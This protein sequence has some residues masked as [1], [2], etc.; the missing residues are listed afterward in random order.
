MAKARIIE[1]TAAALGHAREVDGQTLAE[2]MP[3]L[4]VAAR[5]TAATVLHG[6][7]GRRRA[8]P[9]ENFWQYRRFTSGEPARRIDW[10]RSARDQY[11]YVREREWEVSHT[12][13]LWVDRSRSMWFGS[14]LA[15]DA[16]IERAV[17]LSLGLAEILVDGG[18][19][20]GLLGL[21]RPL[22]N[23]RV[24]PIFADAMRIK[25]E[26]EGFA[27]SA[28][29]GARSE[30][31]LFGDFLAPVDETIAQLNR[32]ASRAARGHIIMIA[33]PIEEVFPFSGRTEFRDPESGLKFI[34]GRAQ[35]YREAYAERL[36][37]HRAAITAHAK[38]LGWTLAIHRSDRPASEPL[39]ALHAR[40]GSLE[41]GAA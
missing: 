18:E 7:H 26:D 37:A 31:V 28:D 34:A 33:D 19:R 21:T 11:L 25:P 13:W 41:A 23:R 9:G 27:P 38:M 4:I 1:D 6:L 10:R 39:L 24:I 8:G 35:D 32:L 40:I 29:I 3:R 15:G 30:V 5:R 36:A 12:V 20:V 17:V 14:N 16:K 2:A 22:A